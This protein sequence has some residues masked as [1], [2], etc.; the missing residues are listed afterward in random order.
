MTR[1]IDYC[2]TAAEV[3]LVRQPAQVNHPDPE[4]KKENKKQHKARAV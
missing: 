2:S 1:T 4:Y 3:H